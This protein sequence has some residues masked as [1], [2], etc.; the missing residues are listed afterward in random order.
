MPVM[1]GIMGC[2]WEH[3]GALW[4]IMGGVWE[5][6]G[7]LWVV[8]GS[9]MEHYGWCVGALWVVCGS[10]RERNYRLKKKNYL[11]GP[12]Y[13]PQKCLVASE[14]DLIALHLIISK[15]NFFQIKR[16]LCKANSYTTA[17]CS[18]IYIYYIYIVGVPQW[19]CRHSG[20]SGFGWTTYFVLP[21]KLHTNL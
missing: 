11:S 12:S 13:S 5:H 19:R 1:I 21:K 3:Y 15:S 8:C 14:M 6:D 2:V 4:N 17:S 16:I 7:T 20:H 10:I 18:L 9:I